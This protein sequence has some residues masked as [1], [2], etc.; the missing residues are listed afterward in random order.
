V[1]GAA[2]SRGRWA[3]RLGRGG[4]RAARR[5]SGLGVAALERRGEGAVVSGSAR[6]GALRRRSRGPGR[7]GGGAAALGDHGGGA[8][9]EAGK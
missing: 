8:A 3:G 5:G 6:R 2:S 4:A 7:S 9:A 1:G